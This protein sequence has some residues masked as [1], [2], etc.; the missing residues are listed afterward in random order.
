[1]FYFYLL[2]RTVLLFVQMFASI[3]AD[4]HSDCI[5]SVKK[6]SLAIGGFKKK[7][8]IVM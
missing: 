7:K 6:D 3:Y 5:L 1:M 4:K 2:N 8:C